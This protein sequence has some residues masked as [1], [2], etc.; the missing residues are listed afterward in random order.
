VAAIAAAMPSAELYVAT[1]ANARSVRSDLKEAGLA[2]ARQAAFGIVHEV[3]VSAR[4][5]I[6]AWNEA[7]AR[8]DASKAGE[9]E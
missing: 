5:C 2:L 6:D 1:R 3:R 4:I 9:E 7:V 8:A